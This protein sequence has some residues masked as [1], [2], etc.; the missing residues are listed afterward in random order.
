MKK[1][2]LVLGAAST[3]LL[4]A[5]CNGTDEPSSTEEAGTAFDS[6]E[7]QHE[8]IINAAHN[9]LEQERDLQIHFEEDLAD[10]ANGALTEGSGQ[11]AEN[12][13]TREQYFNEIETAYAQMESDLS[14]VELVL[15]NG[16]AEE[17][18]S[19]LEETASSLADAKSGIS[20]FI[21]QYS[22]N[23]ERHQ[24]YFDGLGSEEA[25]FQML[26]DGIETLN[27]SHVETLPAW[28]ELEEALLTIEEILADF[29][30]DVEEEEGEE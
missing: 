3:A 6:I 17:L 8:T 30:M 4:L 5:A 29:E 13:S 14:T 21:S 25:D 11:V 22:A 26:A 7:S 9:I 12:V 19:D 18:P 20:S 16:N 27:D 1:M 15:E 28:D 24:Q 2:N 10:D 23:L